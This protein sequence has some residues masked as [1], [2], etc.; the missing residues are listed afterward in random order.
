MHMATANKLTQSVHKC[1]MIRKK[2]IKAEAKNLGFSLTGIT[3]PDTPDHFAIFEVWLAA[4]YQADMK[5]LSRSDTVAKRQQTQ[6]I[7][8]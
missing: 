5:Y 8:A 4:G 2:I 1:Q 3:T 7:D 6:S